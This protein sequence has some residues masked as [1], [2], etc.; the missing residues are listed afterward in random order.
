V[1]TVELGGASARLLSRDVDGTTIHVAGNLED[2]EESTAVLAVS[3]LVAVPISAEVLAGIVWW[4]VGRTLRPVEDIRA[5]VDQI[6]GTR[7]DRRVPEPGT[8]DEIAR[9]AHTMNGMLSRLDESAER[10]RRFV[11]DASHE[12][13]SPLARIRSELDVDMARPASADL[14][15]THRSVLA[16]TVTLQRLVDDL[17]LLA[18][19]DGGALDSARRAPVDLDDLVTRQARRLRAGS[20]LRVDTREVAAAQVLGDDS[21]LQRAIANLLDNA[22]RHARSSI[23]M[24]LIETL[25]GQ[26]VLAVV[27]DGPGIPAEECD[28]VFQRFTRLD[29]A[30]HAAHGGAGLGLAIAREIAERHGGTLALDPVHHPGARFVLTLPTQPG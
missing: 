21:Q 27:D 7:L 19:G 1:A 14:G 3:L 20:A 12:L 22:V 30:R 28:V 16:E 25:D 10:Q 6:S 15:A 5:Q 9:L 23:A 18:R 26:A 17:L 4:S 11:A 8:H 24:T 29:G 13:R 2:V